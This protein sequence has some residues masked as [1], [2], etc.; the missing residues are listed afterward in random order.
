MPAPRDGAA[1]PALVTRGLGLGLGL[2]LACNSKQPA[3]DQMRKVDP[4]EL[5]A[6]R[7]Q[8]PEPA[9]V[10]MK[11]QELTAAGVRIVVPEEWTIFRE[12]DPNFALAFDEGETLTGGPS[13]SIELRRQ[14]RGPLPNGAKQSA[15]AKRSQLDYRRGTTRGRLAELDGPTPSA[16]V[17]LHCQAPR[18]GE[19][20]SAIEAAFESLELVEAAS[21]PPQRDE[22]SADSSAIVELCAATEARRTL[23][24]ARRADGAVFCGPSTKGALERV[25]GLAPAVQLACEGPRTCVRDREGR[26]SCWAPGEAPRALPSVGKARDLAG[27]CIVDEDGRVRCAQPGRRGKIELVELLPFGDP[28][29][30]LSEVQLVLE[31]STEA[32]GCVV[33]QHELWCWDRGGELSVMLSKRERVQPLHP[34]PDATDLAL[35]GDRLCV[36][37]LDQWWCEDPLGHRFVVDGCARRACGCSM[38]G[39]TRMS[40]EH[41]PHERVDAWPLARVH[42]VVAQAGPCVARAEGTLICRGPLESGERD[43]AGPLEGV[44][45]GIAHALTLQPNTQVPGE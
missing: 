30:A 37:S 12:D 35:W 7:E 20:W 34:V 40:C 26:V 8:P 23:V 9:P 33:R 15:S 24:C 16:K 43:E 5:E 27:A 42:G 32:R 36:E 18:A 13:C 29:Q 38:F 22:P 14:G 21:L 25:D 10:P 28:E 11:G 39:A 31:G 19:Q 6:T 45:P 3:R 44:P 4:S 17:L 41:V 2:A 1:A